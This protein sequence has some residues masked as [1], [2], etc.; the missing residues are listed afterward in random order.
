M[1]S[2]FGAKTEEELKRLEDL[3]VP[4]V[5]QAIGAYREIT[6]SPEFRE[7]ERLRSDARHNEASALQH[8]RQEERA[9]WHGIVASRDAALADR[10]AALADRDAEIAR[11]RARLDGLEQ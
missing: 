6:V 10:D 9:K 7:L 5:K 11:L 3:E 2:L 8:A 4:I 1:L